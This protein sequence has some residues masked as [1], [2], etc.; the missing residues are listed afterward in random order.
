MPCGGGVSPAA[1]ADGAH[2]RAAVRCGGAE[3]SAGRRAAGEQ[4]RSEA[5]SSAPP[6]GGLRA[7]LCPG[8][9]PGSAGAAGSC[10]RGGGGAPSAGAALQGRRPGSSRGRV[11]R[12]TPPP[13]LSERE[14]PPPL[15]QD[16]RSSS[17]LN[18]EVVVLGAKSIN[19]A[20]SSFTQQPENPSALWHLNTVIVLYRLC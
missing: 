14:H 6:G 18:S 20:C 5:V 7:G 10:R 4:G 3:G 16:P 9:P 19:T 13:G 2:D 15:G 11:T 1:R 12:G 17:A 8:R